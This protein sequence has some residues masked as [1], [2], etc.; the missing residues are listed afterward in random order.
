MI[1]SKYEKKKIWDKN[2]KQNSNLKTKEILNSRF[3]KEA[4]ER[5]KT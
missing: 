4:Y 2:W 1:M 3:A 5:S